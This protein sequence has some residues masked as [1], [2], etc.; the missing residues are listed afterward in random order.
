MS[1]TQIS[2]YISDDTKSLVEAYSKKSGVKK[3]FLIEDALLHHLQALKEIP[4]DMIIPAKITI[5][6]ES[7]EQLVDIINTPP[8]PTESLKQLMRNA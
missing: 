8:S 6:D 1:E 7:M 5:T 4:L 2:A 3:G